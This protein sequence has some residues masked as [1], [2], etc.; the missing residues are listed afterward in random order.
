MRVYANRSAQGYGGPVWTEVDLAYLRENYTSLP[1]REI[2]AHL[3]RTEQ[4][5]H[6]R[7]S[8]LKLKSRHRTGVNSLVRDYFKV[9]D[10]PMKAWVLGLLAADGSVSKTGQLKLELHEKDA[11]IVQAVRDELAPDAR[12]S[13]YRTRTTPMLRFMVSDPGLR[14]DLASHGVV[15]AKT[16][17]TAWPSGIPAEFVNSFVCGYYDGDG[18]LGLKPLPRWSVVSGNPDFLRIMQEQV[19]EHTGIW[20][21]GP[22][23]DKR[24]EHAWS[25]VQTGEPVRALDAWIHRDVPGLARKRL[26]PLPEPDKEAQ[27]SREGRYVGNLES[28]E[29]SGI[30]GGMRDKRAQKEANCYQLF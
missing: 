7:A 14:D 24:H 4:A 16:L 5:I 9:I 25:I 29:D 21:G 8:R 22:Y 17:I 23:E 11:E 2:A 12:I 13:P 3:G 19:Y 6:N 26:T 28:L 18:S 27:P 20:P 10:T 15:N 30:E 1:A